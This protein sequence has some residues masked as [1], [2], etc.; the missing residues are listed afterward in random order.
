MTVDCFI[1]FHEWGIYVWAPL[2]L[3]F[4]YPSNN[5]QLLRGGST[6]SSSPAKPWE[7]LSLTPLLWHWRLPF[8]SACL[9]SVSPAFH[10]HQVL[11]M[12]KSAFIIKNVYGD[13]QF[14]TL[15]LNRAVCIFL[16]DGE[17]EGLMK[18]EREEIKHAPW[19]LCWRP[20]IGEIPLEGGLNSREKNPLWAELEAWGHDLTWEKVRCREWGGQHRMCRVW[21]IQR[22]GK[23]TRKR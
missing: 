3:G 12:D 14:L 8:P 11:A 18:M 15:K 23:Q 1:F 5:T 13:C 20:G 17:C 19:G 10:R 2:L 4:P 9:H 16:S 6:R 21:V 22:T 7:C